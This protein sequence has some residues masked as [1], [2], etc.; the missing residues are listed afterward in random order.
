MCTPGAG[1]ILTVFEIK[2]LHVCMG[3]Q[4]HAPGSLT[5]EEKKRLILNNALNKVNFKH[6][7]CMR[8]FQTFN[9]FIYISVLAKVMV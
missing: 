9:M 1:C 8:F 2:V 7:M 3:S 6:C 4:N 5:Y